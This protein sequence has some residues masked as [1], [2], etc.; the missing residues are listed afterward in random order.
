VAD[1]PDRDKVGTAP[2]L[3]GS[4]GCQGVQ[5]GPL[6]EHGSLFQRRRRANIEKERRVTFVEQP[7]YEDLP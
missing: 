4:T 1:I 3:G 6:D 2:C 7:R 5:N